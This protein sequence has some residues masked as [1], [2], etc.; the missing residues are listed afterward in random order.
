M[1]L[2]QNHSEAAISAENSFHWI[3]QHSMFPTAREQFIPCGH[4][5]TSPVSCISC[6]STWNWRFRRCC[7]GIL[8]NATG[9]WW[10]LAAKIGTPRRLDSVYWTCP[11]LGGWRIFVFWPMAHTKSTPL[12]FTKDFTRS[13]KINHVWGG[14]PLHSAPIGWHELLTISR[15]RCPY[16][17]TS[18]SCNAL[19]GEVDA[20]K[21]DTSI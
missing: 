19:A 17:I 7:C 5:K 8:S 18:G 3:M 4:S 9:A 20:S 21:P 10:T 12:R 6:H 16:I 2:S 13:K 1:H 14:M 11:H 15:W